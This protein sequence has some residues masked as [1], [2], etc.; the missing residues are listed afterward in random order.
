VRRGTGEDGRVGAR[1]GGTCAGRRGKQLARL[2]QVIH[3]VRPLGRWRRLGR[4]TA[5]ALGDVQGGSDAA[6]ACAARE[7]DAEQHR[8]GISALRL[9]GL[10]LPP[11]VNKAASLYHEYGPGR[12]KFSDHVN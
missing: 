5:A 4:E 1:Y 7:A 10:G 12:R 9:G 2:V 6:E 8:L 3:R 11:S